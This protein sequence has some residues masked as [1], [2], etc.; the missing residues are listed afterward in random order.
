MKYKF[1]S[2]MMYKYF[3]S[4]VY[5][6]NYLFDGLTH[7]FWWFD[8]KGEKVWLYEWLMNLNGYGK[9]WRTNVYAYNGYYM[10]Y[11]EYWIFE[12][13][14]NMHERNMHD[15]MLLNYWMILNA[16]NEYDMIMNLNWAQLY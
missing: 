5:S 10:N 6:Y 12:L 9:Y 3:L 14:R 11:D 13:Q 15:G 8:K 1:L 4:S 16:Y 2:C 7:P